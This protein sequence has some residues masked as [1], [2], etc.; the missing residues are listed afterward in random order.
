MPP[1]LSLVISDS[2]FISS[3]LYFL[4]VPSL[5]S[6]CQSCPC[7]YFLCATFICFI[8]L[9]L[10]PV[11]CFTFPSLVFPKS[12]SCFPPVFPLCPNKPSVYLYLLSSVFAQCYSVPLLH[13]LWVFSLELCFSFVFVFCHILFTS[14]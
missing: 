1:S 12:F 2:R 5:L 7:I 10:A 14:A 3:S 9:I 13:V 8:F 11:F 4:L 6:S